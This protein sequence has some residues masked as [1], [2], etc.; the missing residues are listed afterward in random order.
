M[1]K[2]TETGELV[3]TEADQRYGDLVFMAWK[4]AG[5]EGM[6]IH[7]TCA[8]TGLTVK[9]FNRGKLYLRHTLA[10]ENRRPY[11][12]SFKEN[13]YRLDTES[14]RVQDFLRSRIRTVAYQ[15][16][17]LMNGASAPAVEHFGTEEF[18]KMNRRVKFI[19]EELETAGH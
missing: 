5:D 7:E 10:L 19:V 4:H 1:A 14:E 3:F 13:K 9:Q 16:M 8:E 18:Y 11:T 15:L 2:R 12:Y 6:S 17:L